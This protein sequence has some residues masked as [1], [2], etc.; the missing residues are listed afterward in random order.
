MNKL[1]LSPVLSPNMQIENL[2]VFNTVI[3]IIN[4]NTY[5]STILAV[6]SAK[7]AT[8]HPI[9]V[10]DCSTDEN[11]IIILSKLSSTID[12]Y[13]I[14][15]PLQIHGRTLDLLFR[16]VNAKYILL[17]D[18]DAEITDYSF[19]ENKLIDESDTFGIGFIHGPC[20]MSENS[21]R[22]A[23]FLYYQER[24][25]IPCVILK[26]E[27][28]ME[29]LD[30][31]YSF[32]AKDKY[33]DFP[34]SFIARQFYRRFHFNFFQKYDFPFLKYFR[35]VYYDFYR[36]SMIYYDTGAEIYM[37][38][39]YKCSY[40]FIGLPVK[41]HNRYFNHYHG[42]TRKVLNPDDPNSTDLQSL[43]TVILDRLRNVYNFNISSITN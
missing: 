10:I 5:I 19:F 39:K 40:D 20:P 17:L 25:Y 28:I 8:K 35:R 43:E 15:M 21:M 34:V 11:E 4:V 22:A 6:L 12:F 27:K 36:P 31:G 3:I 23:K 32:E 13:L 14:K 9:I 7:K 1:P 16:T 42:I 30:A 29:A 24:M 26:R 2:P 41:Y 38:L 37:F 33:N 18:S